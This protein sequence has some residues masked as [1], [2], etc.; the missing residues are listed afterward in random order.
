MLEQIGV[1][2]RRWEAL[3]VGSDGLDHNLSVYISFYQRIE[4][5]GT[6]YILMK[7][8]RVMS[9]SGGGGRSVLEDA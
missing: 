3:F 4:V 8:T 2:K 5:E 1:T 9:C 7:V 6:V